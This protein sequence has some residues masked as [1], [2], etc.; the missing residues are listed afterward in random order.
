MKELLDSVP[1]HLQL[2]TASLDFGSQQP[3]QV[4]PSALKRLQKQM[5]FL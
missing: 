3:L 2:C 4:R 1:A 5:I